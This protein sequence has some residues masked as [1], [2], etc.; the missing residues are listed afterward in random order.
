MVVSKVKGTYGSNVVDDE[1]LRLYQMSVLDTLTKILTRSFGPYGSNTCIKKTNS[2]NMYTK[3]GYTILSNVQFTGIIEES[4]RSD[5][6]TI[7][8]NIANTVGDGTTSAVLLS[9]F[10]FEKLNTDNK[11]FSHITPYALIKAL[12]HVVKLVCDEIRNT[13]RTATLEDIYDIALI[14][15]NANEEIAN[16]IRDIYNEC[17]LDVFIDVAMSPAKDTVIKY[18]DGMTLNTG[19]CDAVFVNNKESNTCDI[20]NPSIFFFEDPVDNKELGVL[21][22]T[23]VSKNIIDPYR[24]GKYNEVVPTV[25]ITPKLSRDIASVMDQIT[26]A[27]S[28]LPVNNR[29][30]LLVV[31]DTHQIE[32][33]MDICKMCDA[34]P[35]HKYIDRGVYDEDVKNGLAP[36]PENI[37]EWAGKAERVVSDSSRTKFINPVNKV[38]DEDGNYNNVYTS[39]LEYVESNLKSAIADGDDAHTI[40]SLRRRLNSLKSNMVEIHIGGMTM[41]DRD[42]KRHLLEDAVKNCRSAAINGVGWG[43][44]YSAFKV[45]DNFSKTLYYEDGKDPVEDEILMILHASYKSL[46]EELLNSSNIYTVTVEDMLNANCPYNIRLKSFD[47]KVKSS[48]ES[49]IIIMESVS[50]II[51]LMVTCNQFLTPN[52][53]M[54]VYSDL[55]TVGKEE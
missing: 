39:L 3:D 16:L 25:I 8:A 44:N 19:Y 27:Q 41:A 40:G 33:L 22:N 32:E 43:S 14:S 51:G 17:G 11:A 4:I 30:P 47:G 21:F 15:T 26:N 45:I 29:L 49:D 55:N 31:S 54:N 42:S 36:T 35:I 53:Q 7:T 6:E 52:P 5:I 38:Q 20:D 34:K 2:L 37:T 10:L 1:T 23:I 12:E 18:F 13:A 50:K 24:N 28:Q 46:I 9:K 48:I